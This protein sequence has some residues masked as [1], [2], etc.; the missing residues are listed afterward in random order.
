MMMKAVV[1]TAYG[2]PEVL[3]L[4]AVPVPEPRAHEVRVRVRA[5]A[6]TAADYRIRG[7]N[8]PRGFALPMRLAMG[9]TR[10]RHGILGVNLA[11]E[12][13]AVGAGVARF[14]VGQRVFGATGMTFGAYAEFVCLPES[15]LLATMADAMDFETAA[16]L[17]FGFLTAL[18]Y[19]RG[20]GGVRAGHRVLVVGASGSVGTAAVQLARHFR[21][22][23][24]GV[25]SARNVELVRSLGATTVLDY[26]ADEF[27]RGASIYDI[28][29]E[30]VGQTS[31]ATC[32]ALAK[33]GGRVLLV[34]ADVSTQ[35][36]ALV[37]RLPGG[38]RI[39]AGMAEEKLEDLEFLRGLYES[40]AIRPVIDSVWP[41]DQLVEAHRHAEQGHKRGNLVV[42]VA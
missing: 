40:G 15:G 28:V 8:V 10:P 7:L 27:P 22:E 34:V 4:R 38:G 17:P 37:A 18:S 23:V 20:K 11:G 33:P 3:Q 24:T 32:R 25:C 16:A 31:L 1:C 36:R 2:P 35:L 26:T 30:T 9:L 29:L 5:T 14:R 12:I 41:F 21:A 13:D 6:V 39:V 19:L 42:R